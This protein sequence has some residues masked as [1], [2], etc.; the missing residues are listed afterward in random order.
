LQRGPWRIAGF[1]DREGLVCYQNLIGVWPTADYGVEVIASLVNSPIVNSMLFVKEGKWRNRI[2]TI[3]I[4]PIPVFSETDQKE[5]TQLVREYLEII[6]HYKSNGHEASVV[7]ECQE[8][9]LKIDSLVLRAYDLPPRLERKL[10]D[11]FRGY[12]RPVPFPFPDY[13]PADFKPCIPLH[14]Y[15]E[16]DMKQASAEELLKRIEP[17]DSEVIHEFVVDL[18]ER[19]V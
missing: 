4:C 5:I 14:Q 16:M 6:P 17:I 8:N 11:F 10:L 12:P 3:E 15:L 2:L 1:P 7:K 9:L 18:Q 13:F 19:Q